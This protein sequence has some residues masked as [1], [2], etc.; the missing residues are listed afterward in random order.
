MA[1]ENTKRGTSKGVVVAL[2]GLGFVLATLGLFYS[3]E[4]EGSGE[5]LV[6]VQ[7]PDFEFSSEDGTQQ[8]LAGLRG[9]VVLINYWAFWCEPCLEEMH[10]LQ[11]LQAY[12]QGKDFVLLMVHVGDEKE[13]ALKVEY[14][15][16]N[17]VFGIS[18]RVLE[19]YGV[20]G[21]PH[22]VLIDK[23]GVVRAEFKGPHDWMS[24]SVLKR[25]QEPLG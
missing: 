1:N 7:A 8:T 9:K 23:S 13:E 20:S 4:P 25:I 6:G 18:A 24:S 17:R 10:S 5:T 21:L 2:I 12:L 19:S 16:Q 11:K 3:Y 14:L 22:S 15:P